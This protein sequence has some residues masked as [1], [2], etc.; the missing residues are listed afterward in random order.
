[1][2]D[3]ML[4]AEIQTNN[5]PVATSVRMTTFTATNVSDPR[6]DGTYVTGVRL[7]RVLDKSTNATTA[8]I[9][10]QATA[11]QVGWVVIH[12]SDVYA[13]ADAVHDLSGRETP[14]SSIINHQLP[15]GIYDL[16][17]HRIANF[18]LPKKG[19]YVVNGH[20]IVVK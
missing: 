20:K 15:T 16:G 10:N 7:L 5:T 4:L 17:G 18:P 13:N 3:P 14:Q 9:D 2:K 19:I 1:M 11:D 8:Q 12:Q 6:F